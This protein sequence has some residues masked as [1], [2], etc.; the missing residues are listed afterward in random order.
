MQRGVER[1]RCPVWLSSLP[2]T[3]KWAISSTSK[4]P[5]ESHPEE[6]P[7]SEEES[8]LPLLCSSSLDW[9]SFCL[10]LTWSIFHLVVMGGVVEVFLWPAGGVSSRGQLEVEVAEIAPV[11]VRRG[12]WEGS[13]GVG[14]SG[15]ITMG[16]D[17]FSAA[18]GCKVPTRF[19]NSFKISPVPGAC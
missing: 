2:E 12:D 6:D 9:S 7:E 15:G 10:A 3:S 17:T 11:T 16:M 1:G 4:C 19:C 18:R 13:A 14:G 5:R 8:E